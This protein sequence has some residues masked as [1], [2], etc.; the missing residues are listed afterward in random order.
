MIII[1]NVSQS[2]LRNLRKVEKY[3]QLHPKSK[4]WKKLKLEG[5]QRHVNTNDELRK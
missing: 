2:V 5:Q 3:A 1:G 4:K